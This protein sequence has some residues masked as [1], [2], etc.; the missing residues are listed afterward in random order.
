[1]IV[2]E[3]NIVDRTQCEEMASMIWFDRAY[4]FT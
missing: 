3:L 1:M 2:Y 4:S